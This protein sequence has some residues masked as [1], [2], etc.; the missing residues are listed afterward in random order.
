[1][2]G[3]GA[4]LVDHGNGQGHERGGHGHGGG[5]PAHQHGP[6]SA[7]AQ[8]NPEQ[9]PVEFWEQRY[10]GS[11]PVWSGRVNGTLAAVT[12]GLPPGRSL[13][14]GCGEGGD[15]L[16]LAARGWDATGVD[17]S[18]TA[19]ARARAAAKEHGLETANFVEADLAAWAADEPF[20]SANAATD[21]IGDGFDL[22]T[23]SFFQSPVALPRERILRAAAARVAPGGR[24]VL[25]AHAAA[26]SW[27]AAAHADGDFPTPEAELAALALPEGE[28]RIP[29]AEIREREIMAP[30]G[31]PATLL[32]T[33]V[34]AERLSSAGRGR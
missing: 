3:H 4:G 22:V 33:V 31:T 2:S 14:L 34:V 17:L 20:E 23:A 10:A 18:A 16:W 26:P 5:G 12:Q 15:V 21:P 27:A 30:D 7:G 32:D 11:G 9:A 29:V 25:L 8:A 24:L 6:G 1:M 28:W 19:V 13:D